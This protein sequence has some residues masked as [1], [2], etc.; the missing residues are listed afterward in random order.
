MSSFES[1]RSTLRQS[2]LLRTLPALLLDA[3]AARASEQRYCCGDIV[4]HDGD[5]G[6]S[7]YL[8]ASGEVDIVIDHHGQEFVLARIG[9]GEPFGEMALIDDSPRSATVRASSPELVVLELQRSDLLEALQIHPPA[10][11]EILRLLTGRLR[12]SD[13]V[14]VQ[15]L[16]NKFEAL[17]EANRRLESN[18]NATLAALSQA[19]DLRDQAIFGHSERVSTYSLAIGDAL[20]LP[21]Q[22]LH[23]LRLGALLHDIG[24]IG[25]SDTILRKPGPLSADETQE[26]RL[27]PAWGKR[28]IE[29]IEFLRPALDVVYA[30]HE[31]WDGRGYPRGLRGDDIPLTARI[32]AV[33]DVFDALTMVRPYKLAWPT[34]QAR[35]Q[36]VGESGKAFDPRIVGAFL[37]VYPQFVEIVQKALAAADSFGGDAA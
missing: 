30:H 10:L 36:I 26:M 14:R 4:F 19:L 24:K 18:Y 35:E 8:I 25:V 29:G 6:R 1:V 9:A 31:R 20:A 7:L 27:H 34:A 22:Q 12:A 33:V 37:L 16:V 28:I 23:S 5:S 3:L 32:F 17:A 21:A 15:E 2:P 11:Y 13:S